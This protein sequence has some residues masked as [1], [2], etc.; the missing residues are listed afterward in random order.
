LYGRLSPQ[1]LAF[2]ARL[3]AYHTFAI[4]LPP[5]Y[6]FFCSFHF[7]QIGVFLPFTTLFFGI[8]AECFLWFHHVYTNGYIARVGILGMRC[9]TFVEE[10]H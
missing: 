2:D 9:T 6:A 8:Q 1:T 7:S 10:Y 3:T 4:Q 5:L